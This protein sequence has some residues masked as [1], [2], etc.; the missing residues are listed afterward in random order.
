MLGNIQ[1]SFHSA[2][3]VFTAFERK[4]DEIGGTMKPGREEKTLWDDI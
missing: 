2:V 4:L 3:N 1:N